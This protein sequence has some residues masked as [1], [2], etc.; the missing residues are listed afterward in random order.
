MIEDTLI[1]LVESLLTRI[2]LTK[3]NKNENFY[4]TFFNIIINQCLGINETCEIRR[5]IKQLLS[6]SKLENSTIAQALKEANKNNYEKFIEIVDFYMYR[7]ELFLLLS[8]YEFEK[9]ESFYEKNTNVISKD[10]YSKLKINYQLMQLQEIS[11][12]WTKEIKTALRYYDFEKAESIYTK[13]S[14][15]INKLC[16]EEIF[17]ETVASVKNKIIIFLKA[18]Q[19][20]S[21]D[22]LYEKNKK[23]IEIEWYEKTK[24]I[25]YTELISSIKHKI[26]MLFNKDENI[27]AEE[28]YEKNKKIIEVEWYEK[29]KNTY[30]IKKI[31]EMS[32]PLKNEITLYLKDYQFNLAG[33]VY[34]SNNKI[35]EATWYE[36][37]RNHYITKKKSIETLKKHFETNFLEADSYYKNN[38]AIYINN[39]EY[40]HE[41]VQFIQ[42][43]F[44]TNNNKLD[45]QQ[46]AAVAS[47]GQHLQ[48]IA[49]AGSGKTTTLINRAIFL[50]KHCKIPSK[51]LLILAFNRKAAKEIEER[52]KYHFEE[53]IPHVMTF[54]A[55]AYAIVHPEEALLYDNPATHSQAKS[56]LLQSIIDDYLQHPKFKDKIREL[57]LDHFRDDWKK[58][59]AGRHEKNRDEFLKYRRSLSNLSLRGEYV[60]SYEEKLI[61]DFL[62]EHNIPYRY[63]RNHWWGR[64][65]YRPDFTLFTSANSGIIIEYFDLFGDIDYDKQIDDKRVYWQQKESWEL[66]EITPQGIPKERESFF[67]LLKQL[68]EKKGLICHRLTEDEIWYRIKDRAIDRFTTSAVGFIQ[69][70]RKLSLTTSQ[71]KNIID[72]NFDLSLVEEKFLEI[73]KELYSTYLEKLKITGEEDFDGLMQKAIKNIQDGQVIFEKKSEQ[74]NLSNIR[75]IFI[76]EYQDFSDLF[77]KLIDAIRLNN[78]QIEFFCVGDD[79]QAINGFAGADLKFYNNFHDY[80]NPHEKL[81]LSTNYR[82]SKEIVCI[83]NALMRNFGKPAQPYNQEGGRITLV[84]ISKFNPSILEKEQHNG[85]TITPILLRLIFKL[86]SDNNKINIVLLARK[87]RLPWYI[88]SNHIKNPNKNDLEKYCDLIHSYFIDEW[89]EKI[90]ISTAHKYKGMQNDVVII[91]DAVSRS[92]P[93]IHP[94]WIFTRVLGDTIEKIIDEERRLFYVALTRAISKLFIITEQ[95]NCSPFLQEITSLSKDKPQTNINGYLKDIDWI[96]YLPIKGKNTSMTQLIAQIGNL[97]TSNNTYSIKDQLK[98][99]GFK[100][101]SLIKIWQKSYKAQNFS[102]DSL[103]NSVWLPIAH[104]IYIEIIS[105]N[106]FTLGKYTI[107]SGKWHTIQELA[108]H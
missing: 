47:Y 33:Q 42:T 96:E 104:N 101:N 97:N 66:I 28:L 93:L 86:L 68:L 54:H 81:Y 16:K 11:E 6:D 82:S 39:D 49:R 100:W 106:N 40:Q 9:A 32:L 57:M 73:V 98:S 8:K 59:V 1:S 88:N 67:L 76:D 25:Y 15:C 14:Q 34:E 91:V 89:K 74:G 107:Y 41:K 72:A 7:P 70:C 56:R 77:F 79:W 94:D 12:F 44:K 19:F 69:R 17:S 36:N 45:E 85:D 80:F 38:C 5:K 48:L 53:N 21:A 105:D 108:L 60:K 65:N 84:D 90:S 22:Q 92:Y 4:K 43:W 63:E 3:I 61:A 95:P 2:K 31:A 30:L 35:I 20:E 27:L 55:L 99:D 83:G 62:F 103:K 50:H 75:H 58:I 23:I 37:I 51:Q 71:L 13:N 78:N 18:Y 52:L 46:A 10:N 102:L 26:S 24:N 29:I 64:I 87:N